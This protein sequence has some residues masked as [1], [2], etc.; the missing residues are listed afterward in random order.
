[1]TLWQCC[2]SFLVLPLLLATVLLVSACGDPDAIATIT[3]SATP[4]PAEETATPTATPV[5]P[6]ATPIPPTPTLTPVPK[7]AFVQQYDWYGSNYIDDSTKSA[8]LDVVQEIV[9]EHPE[10]CDAMVEEDLLDVR[11]D[12]EMERITTNLEQLT[13]IARIDEGSAAKLARM[14]FT[15][16]HNS[17][18]KMAAMTLLV[19]MAE[20]AQEDF[21]AFLNHPDIPRNITDQLLKDEK[22]VDGRR[23]TIRMLDDKRYYIQVNT[24]NKIPDAMEDMLSPFLQATDSNVAARIDGLYP[25]DETDADAIT[26]VIRYSSRLAV[27]YPD[28]YS[29]LMNNVEDGYLSWTV[30]RQLVRLAEADASVAA[31][32]AAMTFVSELPYGYN[33]LR[34]QQ[35]LFMLTGATLLSPEQVHAIL[36]TYERQETVQWPSLSGLRIELMNVF[37]ADIAVRLKDMPWIQDGIRNEIAIEVYL[38][39]CESQDSFLNED[40]TIYS[41]THSAILGDGTFIARLL[42]K[43]W[44]QSEDFGWMGAE[45]GS[46]FRYHFDELAL[47]IL[48]MQFLDT[49]ELADLFTI[50]RLGGVVN[51]RRSTPLPAREN[52][53]RILAHPDIGDEITDQNQDRL[54]NVLDELFFEPDRGNIDSPYSTIGPDYFDRYSACE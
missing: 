25:P 19:E 32:V 30:A 26:D 15:K 53:E 14:D 10:L 35:P 43:E 41:L 1:M 27:L 38:E 51:E 47:D 42:E 46:A 31:R 13:Q 6:T 23:L 12:Y 45:A 37:D 17:S 7:L 8:L 20:I 52:F 18:H 48:D 36:D 44:M 50:Y 9:R 54:E 4:T 28:V 24:A 5:P 21:P 29:A 22:Y 3:A 40:D 16:V 49:L 34:A 39:G 2:R 11:L 33:S